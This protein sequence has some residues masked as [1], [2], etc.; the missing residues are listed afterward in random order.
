MVLTAAVQEQYRVGELLPN[1][2]CSL[3]GLWQGNTL[4]PLLVPLCGPRGLKFTAGAAA[5]LQLDW[6]EEGPW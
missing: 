5:G 6:E 1:P 4:R 2:A 3:G